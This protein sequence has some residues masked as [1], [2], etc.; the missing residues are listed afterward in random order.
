M[1][2]FRDENSLCSRC[3][4]EITFRDDCDLCYAISETRALQDA[5]QEQRYGHT[6]QVSKIVSAL[7][8]LQ[9]ELA[10]LSADKRW[11][12]NTATSLYSSSMDLGEV[13]KHLEGTAK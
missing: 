1:N 2:Y 5:S 13:I 7:K 8:E 10:T 3:N 9:N 11:R 6:N 12:D 4:R